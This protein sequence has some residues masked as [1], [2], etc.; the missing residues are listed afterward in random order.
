MLD[1]WFKARIFSITAFLTNDV[2]QVDRLL[3]P[4]A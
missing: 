3:D 4:K 1:S 2:N